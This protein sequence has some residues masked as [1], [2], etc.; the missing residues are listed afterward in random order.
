MKVTIKKLLSLIVIPTAL[1][2]LDIMLF[3][4]IDINL[5][6]IITIII[7]NLAIV[8]ACYILYSQHKEHKFKLN[9]EFIPM[10]CIGIGIENGSIGIILPFLVIAFGW[11]NPYY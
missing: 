5:W 8:I 4:T 10:C 11:V 3:N 9:I 7:I 2:Y 1:I 6:S